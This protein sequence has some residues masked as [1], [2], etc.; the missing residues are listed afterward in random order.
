MR[1][2]QACVSLPAHLPAR[3]AMRRLISQLQTRLS[4]SRTARVFNHMRSPSGPVEHPCSWA[5]PPA[6][7]RSYEINMQSIPG[8]EFAE[9]EGAGVKAPG[10][11]E[12]LLD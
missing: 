3:H 8:T 6:C 5:W 1:A 2:P 11:E 4:S 10:W 12:T 9:L 7:G